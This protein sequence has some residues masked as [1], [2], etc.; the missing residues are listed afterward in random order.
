MGMDRID[1][2]LISSWWK[3]GLAAAE[4]QRQRQLKASAS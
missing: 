4:P 2:N 1:C 3:L